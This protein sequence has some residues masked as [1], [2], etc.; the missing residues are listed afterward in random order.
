MTPE[1]ISEEVSSLCDAF[2]NQQLTEEDRT[3]LEENSP[4]T[5]DAWQVEWDAVHRPPTR[6]EIIQKMNCRLDF[7]GHEAR[8]VTA[9]FAIGLRRILGEA[10][11]LPRDTDYAEHFNLDKMSSLY[12]YHRTDRHTHPRSR[13]A[14]LRIE[15]QYPVETS[16]GANWFERRGEIAAT[17]WLSDEDRQCAD[18]FFPMLDS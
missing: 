11:T 12:W 16:A 9:G 14:A 2:W 7:G 5:L 8:C 1:E 10:I 3:W 6:M 4:G 17:R 13:P 18:D 15:E